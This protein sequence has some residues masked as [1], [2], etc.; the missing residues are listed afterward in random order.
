[1]SRPPAMVEVAVVEVAVKY[2]ARA[3]LPK[4]DEPS[5]ESVAYGE[6][7]PM[8]IDVPKY[9]VLHILCGDEL[10]MSNALSYFGISEEANIA[11]RYIESVVVASPM[12][13][14]FST[15]N[16]EA[17]VVE[18]VTPPTAVIE[19][20][21]RSPS[22]SMMN[23]APSLTEILNKFVSAAAEAGLI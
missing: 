3:E 19:F 6:D 14:S 23:L 12:V 21:N 15:V 22:A 2:P 5:I 9:P 16:V 20:A 7:V 1:M 17:V 18:S 4:A 8:P 10:P 11:F 13:R